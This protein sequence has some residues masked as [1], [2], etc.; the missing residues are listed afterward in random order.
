M[1]NGI[2]IGEGFKFK[3]EI[4]KRL[5]EILKKYDPQKVDI[6]V[7]WLQVVCSIYNQILTDYKDRLDE[8]EG[9]IASIEKSNDKLKK[10][11]K[12]NVLIPFTNFE[13][14]HSVW[15]RIGHGFV[16]PET[17]EV[18]YPPL[19][20]LDPDSVLR[21][22]KP[23]W[24]QTFEETIRHL[25]KTLDLLRKAEAEIKKRNPGPGKRTRPGVTMLSD[26]LVNLYRFYIDRPTDYYDGPFVKVLDTVFNELHP[27]KTPDAERAARNAV[28]KIDFDTPPSPPRF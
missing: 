19:D 23:S 26:E 8:V 11:S 6:F 22:D 5:K 15:D 9:L 16:N 12:K 7:G 28:K 4:R 10:V 20:K 1:K 3:D 27:G 24:K 25:E 21:D 17:R 18:T 14:Y 13:D 2:K